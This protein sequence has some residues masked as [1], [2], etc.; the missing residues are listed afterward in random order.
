MILLGVILTAVGGADI[1]RVMLPRPWGANPRLITL[2]AFCLVVLL[3]AATTTAVPWGLVLCAVIPILL[4]LAALRIGPALPLNAL[5]STSR[6]QSALIIGFILSSGLLSLAANTHAEPTEASGWGGVSWDSPVT[7]L[8]AGLALFLTV[9]SNGLVR[10]ALRQEGPGEH[11]TVPGPQLKGGRWIGPLERITLTGLL[12][13]GAYPVAA[14]LIAAKGIVRFPELQADQ[15][16][17]NKAEYFLVGSFVSW[18]IA[19]VAAGLLHLAALPA[20]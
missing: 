13:T 3:T 18:T 1:I 4:W 10:A 15:E 19:A 2:G 14:A 12:V 20:A 5:A 16:H 11:P 6:R 9:S 7:V 17:G 8:A